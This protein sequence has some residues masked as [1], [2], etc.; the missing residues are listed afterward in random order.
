VKPKEMYSILSFFSVSCLLS[1]WLL[2]YKE[3]GFPGL[4]HGGSHTS[5]FN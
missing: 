3:F 2:S 1:L 4:C 5:S